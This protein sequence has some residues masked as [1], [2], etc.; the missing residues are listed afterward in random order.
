MASSPR[1]WPANLKIAPDIWVST[2]IPELRETSSPAVTTR[3]RGPVF[4]GRH[5]ATASG[6]TAPP[7][8]SAT[9]S[10][11]KPPATEKTRTRLSSTVA[12]RS[13]ARSPPRGGP[14]GFRNGLLPTGLIGLRIGP[15]PQRVPLPVKQPQLPVLHGKQQI[16]L[17]LGSRPLPGRKT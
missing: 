16:G 1:D 2:L 5:Q 9:A 10:C 11:R 15:G 14:S 3:Y 7:P 4:A 6:E 13:R 8:T 12:R 17:G